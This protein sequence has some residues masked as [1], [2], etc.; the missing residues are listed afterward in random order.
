MNFTDSGSPNILSAFFLNNIYSENGND[1]IVFHTG[2]DNEIRSG[3]LWMYWESLNRSLYWDQMISYTLMITFGLLIRN[4]EKSSEL[5]TFNRKS[6]VQRFALLQFIQENYATV[7]LEQVAEK[8]HY[9][10]EHVSRLFKSTTGK[11]F[12]QLLQQVR[13]E[14]AQI[15]L[16]DT[17]LTVADIA[18]QVGYDTTEHFIRLFKKNLKITPTEYRKKGI[19]I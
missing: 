9:T 16:S 11:T 3:F 12:T 10:P 13:I 5:P 8:F 17:N 7:T 19:I 6:D 14:K 4:Y 2:N 15:L 18:S 1:Y